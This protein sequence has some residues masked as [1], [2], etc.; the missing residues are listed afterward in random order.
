L[1]VLL[2]GEIG[3]RKGAPYVLQAARSTKA[4]AEFRWCGP[5]GILPAAAAQLR[6]H[7]ELRGI[8][9]R[10]LMAEHY[11][12]A[13]VF[14]LPSICEGSAAVCYEALAAGVPVITTENAGSVVRHGIEGFI[15]P[16]RDSRAIAE[17]LEML[18]RD[19]ELLES[20]SGAALE[21]ARD[22]TLKKYGE[23]LLTALGPA[24]GATT[25]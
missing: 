16:I 23:R 19:P 10:Q 21:R 25:Q 1:R 18:H 24:C 6:E 12:W 17:R 7:V 11:A 5:V 14:L 8:V 4:L 13:D 15:V 20:M 9:P 3:F 2:A 22:F